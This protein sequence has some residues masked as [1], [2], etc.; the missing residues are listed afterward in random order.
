MFS[1]DGLSSN[2]AEART[3]AR[4]CQPPDDASEASPRTKSSP[5]F[6]IQM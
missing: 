2:A 3:R 1:F 5:L 4:H 6:H